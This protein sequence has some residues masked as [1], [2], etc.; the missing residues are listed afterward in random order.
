MT[1]APR[2]CALLPAYNEAARIGATVA[3][4]RSRPEIGRIVVV[5][6]GS[7]D[8][9]AARARDAGADQVITRTNGGKGAALTTA[10][11]AE[12]DGADIFLLLDADLGASATECV[13]LLPPLWNDWADMTIGMLP[14]DP[15]F[16]ASGRRGGMGLV[17]RL[18]R[19]GIARRAGRTLAQPLSGQ[20]A[21][22]RVV[23]D[24]ALAGGA[25]ARGFGV[26]V[27][28]TLDALQAGFRVH[29]VETQ[30]RHHV[31]GSDWSGLR[32]RTRQLVDVAR[33][34]LASPLPA[35]RGSPPSP[36]AGR[37]L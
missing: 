15:A 9:T 13:K 11:R 36:S 12:R 37:G 27:G 22:R 5:D 17:V 32:H 7:A 19:W 21:V 33:V 18:A 29:E 31:T 26:E 35:R 6:D 3:A 25:F 8:D 34:V 10:Y 20:R 2:V 14:P 24:A 30:F 23:L 16:A 4:L 28:L 1:D